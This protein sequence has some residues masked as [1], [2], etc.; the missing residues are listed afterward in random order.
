MLTRKVTEKYN[1]FLDGRQGRQPGSGVITS[2]TAMPTID[3]ILIK[4]RIKQGL[5]SSLQLIIVCIESLGNRVSY[6]TVQSIRPVFGLQRV[7]EHLQSSGF[8]M[9]CK[10]P[11]PTKETKTYQ[12]L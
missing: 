9:F 10:I 1:R 4:S 2:T 7:M 8:V 5:L 12:N 3:Q 6:V 11:V